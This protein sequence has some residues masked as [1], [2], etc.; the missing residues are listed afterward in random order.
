MT[1]NSTAEQNVIKWQVHL[2]NAPD[3]NNEEVISLS[4]FGLIV[5]CLSSSCTPKIRSPSWHINSPPFI[6]LNVP[7]LPENGY[8]HIDKMKWNLTCWP[9]RV[10]MKCVLSVQLSHR[11]CPPLFISKRRH[12]NYANFADDSVDVSLLLRN[13]SSHEFVLGTYSMYRQGEMPPLP[14]QTIT[15]LQKI[16]C[17]DLQHTVI[18]T[19]QTIIWSLAGSIII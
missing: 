17:E 6:F 15:E 13:E 11:L 1:W 7:P 5:N 12:R 2:P 14:S 3:I 10:R 4:M 19:Q 8:F 16:N 18:R 9:Q